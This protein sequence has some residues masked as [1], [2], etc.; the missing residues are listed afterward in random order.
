MNYLAHA[1]LS[2]QHEELLV[3]NM[4]SDFVK[5]NKQYEYPEGIF[6]GIRLHRQI[7]AF[8][9]SHEATRSA[10]ALFKP[11]V[12]RYAP[13]FVDVAYDHFLAN[14]TQ[15]FTPSSLYDF[16]AATYEVLQKHY[17]VLPMRF[18]SMLTYMRRDNWLFNYIHT[19]GLQ[20]SMQ[21]LVH[22]AAYLSDAQPAYDCFLYHYQ[23]LAACYNDFIADVKLFSLAE[24][25]KLKVA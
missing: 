18:Q 6:K 13:A 14:D 21:G 8:T 11:V 23:E 12:A 20:R 24:I 19:W 2:F 3:G 16:A 17:N 10:T 9:D 4:I 1:Y 5:G 7:D 22:R 15:V 25:E